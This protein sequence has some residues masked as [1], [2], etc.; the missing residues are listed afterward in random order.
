MRCEWWLGTS[1]SELYT[2]CH[3][4]MENSLEIFS[5]LLLAVSL[6]EFLALLYDLCFFIDFFFFRILIKIIESMESIL[7]LLKCLKFIWKN[8]IFTKVNSNNSPTYCDFFID[9][10]PWA[11]VWFAI[12][13]KFWHIWWSRFHWMDAQNICGE[14]G[15]KWTWNNQYL[16][17]FTFRVFSSS[18]F[19][20]VLFGTTI[21]RRIQGT[22]K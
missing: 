15:G 11:P 9:Y 12:S 17:Y 16:N 1:A 8:F 18:N 10:I 3:I 7:S 13:W 6:F 14:Y 20:I 22:I 19:T 2:P 5:L 4:T 21:E